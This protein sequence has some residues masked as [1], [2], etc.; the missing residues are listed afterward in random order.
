MHRG[1]RIFAV[2]AAGLQLL[3]AD[4]A[5]A[6]S[7]I[8]EARDRVT[9]EVGRR[10]VPDVPSVETP[11]SALIGHASERALSV[12][13]RGNLV[14]RES[15]AFSLEAVRKIH[16]RAVGAF[17]EQTSDAQGLCAW[18]SDQSCEEYLSVV[19]R[20]AELDAEDKRRAE[21]SLC[22][23]DSVACVSQKYDSH[24]QQF[25]YVT[26]ASLRPIDMS[27]MTTPPLRSEWDDVPHM[28]TPSQ[29]RA[30]E[31]YRNSPEG[32]AKAAAERAELDA[33]NEHKRRE[34]EAESERY[35][36]DLMQ[37]ID[38]EIAQARNARA[39][40]AFRQQQQLYFDALASTLSSSG[41][42][43]SSSSS[44]SSGSS[45]KSRSRTCGN[46]GRGRGAVC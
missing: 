24:R 31:D 13:A 25:F 44:S 17:I 4:I 36:S 34:R 27:S 42:S 16:A 46:M 28:Y 43:S 26:S 3:A 39:A 6:Q 33:S 23:A 35:R 30:R 5:A 2:A 38:S 29:R 21:A 41:G 10:A 12:S 18:L 7:P 9:T 19:Q 20:R 45:S 32:R 1:G 14:A 22:R 11:A 8:R 37:R 15:A 40:A